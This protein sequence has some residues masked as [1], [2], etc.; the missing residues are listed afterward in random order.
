MSSKRVM[1]LFGPWL[2][3]IFNSP[4]KWGNFLRRSPQLIAIESL[5]FV[6]TLF[7]MQRSRACVTCTLY[8]NST[9]FQ[10]LLIISYVQKLGHTQ[11]KMALLRITLGR[12]LDYIYQSK[13]IGTINNHASSTYMHVFPLDLPTPPTPTPTPTPIFYFNLWKMRKCKNYIHGCF[14][15]LFYFWQY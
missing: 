13:K 9:P 7:E 14:P 10:L 4:C 15:L 5:P 3:I 1:A 12:G 2:K 8:F 6:A 11:Q